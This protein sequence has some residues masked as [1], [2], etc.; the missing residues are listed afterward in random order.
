MRTLTVHMQSPECHGQTSF[1]MPFCFLYA[2]SSL[3]VTISMVSC[4]HAT[5]LRE[6]WVVYQIHFHYNSPRMASVSG[7]D[8]LLSDWKHLQF[9]FHGVVPW[10]MPWRT[11]PDPAV[12]FSRQLS[13]QL[14]SGCLLTTLWN[15]LGQRLLC[16]FRWNTATSNPSTWL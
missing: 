15:S 3:I 16:R 7:A 6:R 5:L 14:P 10:L 2:S 13:D 4:V 12:F 9:V 8:T 1:L 11:L